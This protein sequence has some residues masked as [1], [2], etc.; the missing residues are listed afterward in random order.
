ML[1][2]AQSS[3]WRLLILMGRY[4]G[5][6]VPS[7][8][9]GLTWGDVNFA[10]GRLRVY[11][12]K[13]R[14]ERIVPIFP[15]VRDELM[16]IYEATSERRVNVFSEE[17]TKHANLGT[18]LKRL[19][20]RAELVNSEGFRWKV[21]RAS[22][23]TEILQQYGPHIESDWIGRGA[24]VALEHYAMTLNEDFAQA[25]SGESSLSEFD[26]KSAL[27]N[28]V[29]NVHLLGGFT[30]NEEEGENSEFLSIPLESHKNNPLLLQG[31]A[32]DGPYW[33]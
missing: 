11:A 21:M 22:R 6:R 4:C 1:K 25:T 19:A 2:Y 10:E 13:T 3:E 8:I 26:E 29:Q 28:P 7:E 33:T 18:P 9:K 12:P 5:V 20:K 16:N 32:S 30:G 17:I 15:E 24:D 27:Q 14:T 31:V 23:S